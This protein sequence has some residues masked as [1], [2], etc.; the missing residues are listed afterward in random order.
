MKRILTA[1]LA[2]IILCGPALADDKKSVDQ[3]IRNAVNRTLDILKQKSLDKETKKQ[4]VV[5]VVTPVFD[6]PLMAKLVLGRTHWPKLSDPQKKEF[7]DL[8]YKTIQESYFDKINLFTN[9]RVE[10]EEP[11]QK[12]SKFQMMTYIVAKDKRY[13]MLFKLYR[14]DESWKVYDVEIEGISF[15]KSFG[16]Q[17]DQ[18]LQQNSVKD[19][20]AKLRERALDMPD[21]L[22][23]STAK[24]GATSSSA[25]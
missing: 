7:S 21:D 13:S 3:L 14:K 12:E 19:L 24:E 22:K 10:F 9:E 11:V 6:I 16:S 4:Q 17:Y 18:F 2:A 25:R 23:A 20:L 1:A 15:I 5:Q 8:F